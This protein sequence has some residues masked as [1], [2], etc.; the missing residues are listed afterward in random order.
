MYVQVPITLG[1]LLFIKI[2]SERTEMKALG[3]ADRSL[4]FFFFFPRATPYGGS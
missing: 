1:F 2:K 4:L 3:S